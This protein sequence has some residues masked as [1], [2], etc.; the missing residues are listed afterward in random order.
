M[1]DDF[2]GHR[3]PTGDEVSDALRTAT[4]VIDTN[5]LFSLYRRSESYRRDL[6]AVL[7]RFGP[8]LFVPHQVLREYWRNRL[9]VIADRRKGHDEVVKLIE[10]H[11]DAASRAVRQWAQVAAVAPAETDGLTERLRGLEEELLAAV[12]AYEPDRVG[13]AGGAAADPVLRELE[14]LLHGSVG[15]AMPDAEW[16]AA[17]QRGAERVEKRIPPG[18]LD[19]DKSDSDRPEGASG[20]YLVWS[21]A[22]A[23]VADRDTDLVLVTDDQKE[24][25]WLRHRSVFVGPRPELV[26]ELHSVCGARLIL[27]RTSELLER[28]ESAVDV[29]VSS[30]SVTEARRYERSSWTAQGVAELLALLDEGELP[31]ADVIRRAAELGGTIDRAEVYEVCGFDSSRLLTG[32]TKPVARLTWELQYSGVVPEGVPPA[33]SPLY[34]GPGRAQAFEVPEEIVEL[35]TTPGADVDA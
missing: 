23:E 25:W 27:L 5:V 21:Q 7:G 34:D 1:Y 13:M 30:A 9:Q 20:D 31:Q 4:V 35:L 28:A 14:A 32:F 15:A 3:A 19:A 10:Q 29:P 22:M 24:D 6:L 8:R 26:A 18:Y 33:L 17:V 11:L 16:T 12:T 2:V